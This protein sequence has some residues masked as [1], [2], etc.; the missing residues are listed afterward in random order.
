M[1]NTAATGACLTPHDRIVVTRWQDRARSAGFDRMVIHDRD[2]GDA[3]D[4]G[5]FLSVY[6]NGQAWS[7]WGFA[8]VGLLVRAWCCLTGS[9]VGQFPTLD[10]ALTAVLENGVAKA[11]IVKQSSVKVRRQPSAKKAAAPSTPTFNAP[12]FSAPTFS[13]PTFSAPTFSASVSNLVAFGP[14]AK[15][16]GS[17]A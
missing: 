3:S 17:A 12:S 2:D 1:Q 16:L 10:D 11:G 6:S 9:D 8:R 13:A 15:R 14:Y 5:N 4:V 7:R